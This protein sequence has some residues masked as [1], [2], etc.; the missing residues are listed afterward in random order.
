M[1]HWLNVELLWL[2]TDLFHQDYT[3]DEGSS[4]GGMNLVGRKKQVPGKIT[5]GKTK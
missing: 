2:Q 3:N 4:S 1:R 5:N